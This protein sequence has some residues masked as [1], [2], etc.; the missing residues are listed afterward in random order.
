LT[1]GAYFL[2]EWPH[3]TLRL[4]EP[5][6]RRRF[7]GRAFIM[8]VGRSKRV[9]TTM[10]DLQ[11][12]RCFASTPALSAVRPWPAQKANANPRRSPRSIFGAAG[13][14]RSR[15]ARERREDR[16]LPPRPG[17]PR[18]H[19]AHGAGAGTR[20]AGA[21]EHAARAAA[22]P[23]G[24]VRPANGP[25]RARRAA[26]GLADDA[27]TDAAANRAGGAVAGTATA[28]MSLFVGLAESNWRSS[29][30]SIKTGAYRRRRFSGLARRG[31]LISSSPF[32]SVPPG[33]DERRPGRSN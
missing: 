16:G 2:P 6:G 18:P 7:L 24:A 15:L 29:R 20:A 26:P 11:S 8:I 9:K 28:S 13:G 17:A 10:S 33:P 32:P 23:D 30:D 5:L 1:T 3:V 31:F 21:P 4:E 14:S 25:D 22:G 27:G 12:A 19:S